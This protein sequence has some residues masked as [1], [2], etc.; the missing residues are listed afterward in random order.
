MLI[1][2]N[3]HPSPETPTD[4][5][6]ADTLKKHN[7]ILNTFSSSPETD[8]CTCIYSVDSIAYQH[9]EYICAYDLET[10]AY[11]KINDRF[12]VFTQTEYAVVGN[13]SVTRFNNDHYEVMLELK[14]I[15]ET[16]NESTVQWGSI[17]INDKNGNSL[18]TPFYGGCACLSPDKP[19]TNKK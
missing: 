13:S 17:R 11:L 8:S 10:K 15:K 16:G 2:C 18:I 5:E 1:A 3:Q 19:L 12:N 9:H 7:I 4:K 14:D 6:E